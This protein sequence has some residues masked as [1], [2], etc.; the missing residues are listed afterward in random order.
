MRIHKTSHFLEDGAP[1]HKA[2]IVTKW[3]ADRPHITLIKWPGNSPD[4][5]PTENAWSWMKHQLASST[6]STMEE[7]ITEIKRL[8][9]IK[10]DDSDYLRKLMDSMPRRLEEVKT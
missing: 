3:F 1:C 4:L 7:W 8:W 2:K 9:L 6:C 5:N 10:M